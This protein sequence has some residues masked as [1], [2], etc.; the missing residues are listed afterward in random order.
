[1]YYSNLQVKEQLLYLS[2]D[3]EI[4]S[5]KSRQFKQSLLNGRVCTCELTG[6]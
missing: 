3:L 4:R 5:K 1:M 6:N 2:A